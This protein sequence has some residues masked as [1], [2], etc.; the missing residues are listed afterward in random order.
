MRPL[1][2]L[3]LKS[4][5]NRRLTV[6]LAVL[7]LTVSV[8]LLLGVEQVRKAARASF[9]QTISGT[10]LIVGARSG[11]VQLLLY[12]VFHI[13]HATNQVSWES[14]REIASSGLVAW[15]VPI[16]LG[17]SHRGYRV[18]GTTKDLF[19]HYRYARTREIQFAQG[20]AFSDVFHAVVGA[21]VAE[22]LDY[23]VGREIVVSHGVAQTSFLDHDD[24]PFMVT[25]VLERTGTPL[26]RT[27]LVTLEGIEAIHVDWQQGRPPAPGARVPPES[28]RQM[29]LEPASIT[30]FLVGLESRAATF[31]LQRAIND[32]SQEPLTAVLPGVALSELWAVIGTVEQALLAISACVVVAGLIGMVAMLLTSLSERRREMAILRAIGARPHHVFLLFVVEAAAIGILAAL[33]GALLV[34]GGLWLLSEPVSQITGVNF[35]LTM[36]GVSEGLIVALVIGSSTCAGVIP[37]WKAYRTALADGLAVRL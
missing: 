20:E 16:A 36:P 28:V 37:A 22:R 19:E 12:S 25:G 27:V 2:G 7:A 33:G 1:L 17:D 8:S 30:A 15:T 10:D 34:F 24:K 23:E 32:Y 3:A 5:W 4:L 31:R 9:T 14:Y 35:G 21:E 6:G 26:D 11:P 18:M 13:G 29:N